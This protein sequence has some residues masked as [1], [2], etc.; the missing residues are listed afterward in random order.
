MA[1]SNQVIAC[2]TISTIIATPSSPASILV[3]NQGP[4]TVV[5]G[6]STGPGISPAGV[7]ITVASGIVTVP[8]RN[9]GGAANADDA[10]YARVQAPGPGTAQVAVFQPT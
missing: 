2:G 6:G 4:G 3:Q 7:L 8:I 10:L 5:L 1:F 9:Y